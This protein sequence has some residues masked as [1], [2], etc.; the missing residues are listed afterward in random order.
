MTKKV[1]WL[2]ISCLMALSLAIASCGPAVTEEEEEEEVIIGEEEEEEEE[3]G[4]VVTGPEE[5]KYG[6]I[7]RVVSISTVIDW[8]EAYAMTTTL[9][10]FTHNEPAEG[11]WTKGP[12]GSGEADWTYSGCD[13]I[14]LKAGAVIESWD[15]P[16]AGH[17]VFYVRQGVHYSLDPTNEASALVGGREMTAEDIAYS[18]NRV[19]SEPRAYVHNAYPRLAAGTVITTPD[20]WTV[21]I[22]VPVSEFADAHS[23]F[24]DRNHI[25]AREVCE[26]YGDCNDWTRQ[27]GT[28]PFIIKDYVVS[29]AVTF[30][31]NPNYWRTDPLEPGKGNQLPYVDGAKLLI[32]TDSS[33][34]QAAIR[35]GK[36]DQANMSTLEDAESVTMHAPELLSKRHLA[37]ATQCI[38]MHLYDPN[39]PTSD[40]R[41]RQALM[42]ATDLETIADELYVGDAETNTWPFPYLKEYASM[43]LP[44]DEWPEK[45]KEIYT[46]N[47]TKAKALL[48][49]AGYPN[50]FKADLDCRNTNLDVDFASVI[51]DQWS[52]IGVDLE[53]HPQ[54]QGV[55][56]N[57]WR[58]FT[59]K[60]M[61]IA[62]GMGIGGYYRMIHCD[63]PSMW[64]PSQVNDAHVKEVKA[65]MFEL[66]NQADWDGV[67]A[68]FKELTKYGLEQVWYIPRPLPYQYNL[69][70]PWLK[71]YSG[72]MSVGWAGPGWRW[73]Q[74]PWVDQ[75]LKKSMGY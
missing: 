2:T 67:D 20:K 51:E 62:G 23:Q 60:D 66:F 9:G 33:T 53:I 64:N 75:E 50:G 54:E 1:L 40:V 37:H 58:G 45:V 24:F 25:V 41:V 15:L 39:L 13:R 32:I 18:I 29:S 44:R 11:D 68:E 30:D 21:D 12:T 55:H 4:G 47:P 6:G 59:Y 56:M 10:G 34:L 42:M 43:F 69:W 28:G 65:K 46:Y 31:R 3:Q 17:F 36:V 74:Y 49:E 57:L 27:V 72:E 73:C 38:C 26:K 5:P 61:I 16:E 7:L 52:K 22:V 35:T 48:A 71:K 63:T 70:W 8:D 19:L 14:R